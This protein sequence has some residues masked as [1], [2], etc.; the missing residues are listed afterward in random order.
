MWGRGYF[1]ATVG[2]VTEDMIKAYVEKQE[3]EKRDEEF[4]VVEDGGV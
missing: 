1:C 3:G 4:K 2:A